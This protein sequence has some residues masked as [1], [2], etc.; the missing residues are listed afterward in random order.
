MSTNWT[1]TC[2]WLI[3]AVQKHISR[4]MDGKLFIVYLIENVQFAV[5]VDQYWSRWIVFLFYRIG[6]LVTCENWNVILEW[7]LLGI[8]EFFCGPK[9]CEITLHF[10]RKSP[11]KWRPSSPSSQKSQDSIQNAYANSFSYWRNLK[12]VNSCT[13]VSIDF[14]SFLDFVNS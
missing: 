2:K 11:I 1:F 7:P 10:S 12:A 3:L 6:N 5:D 9:F 13:T 8:W 14:Y 4:T